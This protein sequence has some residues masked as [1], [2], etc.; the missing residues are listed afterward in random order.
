M[1]EVRDIDRRAKR[2]KK[3]VHEDRRVTIRELT[4]SS[5]RCGAL[6]VGFCTLTVFPL[7]AWSVKGFVAKNGTTVVPC[8]PYFPDLA[9]YEP[10]PSQ[11]SSYTS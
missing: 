11:N 3:L 6:E 7:S 5:G 4:A 10:P 8:P 2:M 1:L 9:P